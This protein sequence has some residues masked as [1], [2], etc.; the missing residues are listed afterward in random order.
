MTKKLLDILKSIQIEHISGSDDIDI[1]GI[2]FDSR[3]TEKGHLFIATEGINTDGH[4]FIEAAV[5][6]GAVAVMLQKDIDLKNVTC[7]KT[8]NTSK[9]LA[10]A[11]ANFYNNPSSKL[12]LVGI[13]GTNGK[14]TVATLLYKLFLSLGFK[15]GLISTVA[16]YINKKEFKAKYTTPDALTFN[17]LLND[18]VNAGCEY[19]FAE[20]SSHSVVQNRIYGL[21]FSGGIFTNLTHDHLDYHKSFSEYLKAKKIF[22]DTLLKDSFA[23]INT[24]DK[25]GSVLVQNTKAT[26]STYALKRFADFK[27]KIM[28]SHIDSMLLNINGTEIWTLLTGIFNAYNL[29]AVYAT[30]LLMGVQAEE[31]LQKLSTLTSV[32][33]RFETI[34]KHGITAIIDYAHT[35]DALKNVLITINDIKSKQSKL[36]TIIGAGGNRDKSKRPLMAKIAE[37]QSDK[38]ILTS[39]NPRNENPDTI[40]DDMYKG[41]SGKK[42]VLKITNREEAVKTAIFIA[43]K[44]DIILIA[45]KGHET[46]QEINGVR[47]HMDDKEI[48]ENALDQLTN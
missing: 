12:K 14:T 20:I 15:V 16:N 37:S 13:T 30:A 23:L 27:V 6:K 32:K 47:H 42:Q 28:E 40:I 11:S 33:G 44:G 22:F 21:N 45:G 31:V 38:V 24:D 48:A 5:K 18:M 25:N 10:I 43:N 19:C 41:I 2:S 36:I 17:S 9:G 4:M 26:I 46:Y 7:I 39:D 35:P 34:K 1:S 8:N 29:C 3:K